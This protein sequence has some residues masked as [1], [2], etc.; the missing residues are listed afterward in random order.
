MVQVGEDWLA[1]CRLGCVVSG[2]ADGLAVIV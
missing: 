2:D 1:R